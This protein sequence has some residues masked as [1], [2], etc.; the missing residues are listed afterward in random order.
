MKRILLIEPNTTLAKIYT[1]LFTEDSY[2]VSHATNAQ[3][4][5]DAADA[6]SP[7]IVMLELQLPKHSGIEFLHEFRSYPE[8]NKVPVVINSLAAPNLLA[9]FRQ[10]LARD[11][12]VVAILYKPKASLDVLRQTIQMHLAAL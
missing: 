11:L 9:D 5:I 12:D 8:W 1:R 10:A 3:S 4:A 7:D 2:Q 6:A